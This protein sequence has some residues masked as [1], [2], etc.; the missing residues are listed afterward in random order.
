MKSKDASDERAVLRHRC[1]AARDV[2]ISGGAPER[3]LFEIPDVPDT[4]VI[5]HFP[6]R[7]RPSSSPADEASSP[8]DE[9][10]S[11]LEKCCDL[12]TAGLLWLFH[13]I[14]YGLAAYADAMHPIVHPPH[15]A[16]A[17]REEVPQYQLP[18]Q[19]GANSREQDAIE[20]RETYLTAILQPDARASSSSGG[21]SR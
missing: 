13:E 20:R 1:A 16:E 12:I 14:V 21:H 3:T 10:S 11:L 19:H 5:H 15:R 2:P 6:V 9:A 7:P 18:L 17:D 8:A 4:A